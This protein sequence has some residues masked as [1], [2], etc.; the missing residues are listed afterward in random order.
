MLDACVPL[1][2][3]GEMTVLQHV[4]FCAADATPINGFDLQA[5]AELERQGRLHQHRGWNTGVEQGAE[6]HVAGDP[7]EAFE[8]SDAHELSFNT[9]TT[10][11]LTL[12]YGLKGDLFRIPYTA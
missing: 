5:C 8:I 2:L 4:H 3:V 6:E 11:R 10:L 7:G 9:G 1:L 12:G